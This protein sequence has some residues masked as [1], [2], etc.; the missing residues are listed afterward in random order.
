M[1]VRERR[2]LCR[3][4]ARFAML[5]SA[6]TGRTG[7]GTAVHTDL[8]DIVLMHRPGHLAWT[9]WALRCA[10]CMQQCSVQ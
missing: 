9:Y 7:V 6:R 3:C 10:A 4:K 1:G 5:S 2:G 8:T